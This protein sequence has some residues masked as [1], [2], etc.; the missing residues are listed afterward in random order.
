MC[1]SYRHVI[2]VSVSLSVVSV[3]LIPLS[4]WLQNN[5]ADDVCF[6][7]ATDIVRLAC[8]GQGRGALECSEEKD[9]DSR[10]CWQDTCQDQ[11]HGHGEPRQSSKGAAVP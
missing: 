1:C 11:R 7:F 9:G 4:T 2:C 6:W 8:T 10:I 5:W 3:P